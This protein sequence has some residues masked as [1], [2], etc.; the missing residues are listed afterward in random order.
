[1]VNKWWEIKRSIDTIYTFFCFTLTLVPLLFFV[2]FP[3]PPSTNSLRSPSDSLTRHKLRFTPT[4]E[5]FRTFHLFL[6]LS[7]FI[8]LTTHT[9]LTSGNS[10]IVD[11]TMCTSCDNPCQPNP[12][13]P[14]PTPSPPRPVT[15]SACPP[16]PSSGGGG[17]SGG[18]YYYYP[19]PSQSGSYGPP[20]SSSGGDGGYV[21]PP[22][23]SGGNYPFTPPPN[24][25]VPYFPFYHYNPPPQSVVLSGS[26]S[27][28]YGFSFVLGFALFL[29]T[30][31]AYK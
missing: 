29:S 3:L 24:P 9:T 15:I 16:P 28:S 4:M 2:F 7:H 14:P 10:Q 19:P 11:C 26:T 18:P 23:K 17:G 20:P 31:V 21:Y 12:S 30:Y 1:M 13:P 25:I 8:F 27:L 5:T 6:F 22:P